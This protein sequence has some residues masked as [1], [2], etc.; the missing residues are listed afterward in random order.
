MIT[1]KR[2]YDVPHNFEGQCYVVADQTTLWL[3]NNKVRHKENEPA[4]IHDN[5]TKYW[6]INNQYHRLDGPAIEMNDYDTKLYY[7]N[8]KR[9]TTEDYWNHPLVIEYKLKH[10][11]ET[12]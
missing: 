9:L 8:N 11:L 3:K 4:I 5:R 6:L 7:I 1:F 12:C 10:I 2:W